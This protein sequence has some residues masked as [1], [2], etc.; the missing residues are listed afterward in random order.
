MSKFFRPVQFYLIPKYLN[1]VNTVNST[2][3]DITDLTNIDNSQNSF[4]KPTKY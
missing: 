2:N 1:F 4:P 3:L